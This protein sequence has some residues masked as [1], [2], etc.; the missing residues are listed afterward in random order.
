V[1]LQRAKRCRAFDNMSLKSGAPRVCLWSAHQRLEEVAAVTGVVHDVPGR[2][3]C[4]CDC[5]LR[6]ERPGRRLLFRRDAGA[7][8]R[9]T[10]TAPRH[11]RRSN[12]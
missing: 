6:I 12:R 11:V 1:S 7:R 3:S 9:S 2:C 4:R 8:A 10:D 5:E